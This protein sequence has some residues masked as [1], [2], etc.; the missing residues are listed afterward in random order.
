MIDVVSAAGAGVDV[1]VLP[2]VTDVSHVR[3][4]DLLLTQVETSHGLN[5]VASVSTPRSR[6]PAG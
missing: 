3:A 6:T 4:L 5:R 1:I 2:K